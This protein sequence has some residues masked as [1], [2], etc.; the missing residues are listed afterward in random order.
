MPLYCETFVKNQLFFTLHKPRCIIGTITEFITIAGG[1]VGPSFGERLAGCLKRQA[2]Q[3]G[4]R[5]FTL[6]VAVVL[7]KHGYTG[8]NAA[9]L[10]ARDR[11]LMTGEE[12]KLLQAGQK[13][14]SPK[15]IAEEHLVRD[16][17]RHCRVVS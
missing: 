16:F 7:F 5:M 10:V 8:S 15:A 14:R 4:P 1:G 17:L 12:A 9:L 2:F 6:Q 3:R 13:N 11:R